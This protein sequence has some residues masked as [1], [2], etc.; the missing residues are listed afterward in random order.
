M[1]TPFVLL[2]SILVLACVRETAD[3]SQNDPSKS[4]TAASS[5]EIGGTATQTPLNTPAP[6]EKDE[7]SS[8][9]T[10]APPV[11][12]VHLIEYAIH[13][14]QSVPAGRVTF[15]VENA[16][17]EDHAFEIEGH[18]IHQETQVLKRGDSASM[19]VDLQPGT[20]TVYCPVKDHKQKGMQ[21]TL[22]V[23]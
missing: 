3:V 23:Q 7:P 9:A 20:Y 17:K 21:T 14:P 8:R 10:A 12:S 16:G 2:L 13:M 5:T 11:Q 22:R 19:S 1:R 18:G 15:N 6:V 4:S